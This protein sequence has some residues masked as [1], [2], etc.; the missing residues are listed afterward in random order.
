M[1]YM[2]GEVLDFSSIDENGRRNVIARPADF[3]IERSGQNLDEMGCLDQVGRKRV[4]PFAHECLTNSNGPSRDVQ[5]PGPFEH[6]QD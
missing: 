3:Y 5:P 2:P 1:G 6:I 4:G